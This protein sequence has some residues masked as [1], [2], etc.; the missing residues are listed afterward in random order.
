MC[1]SYLIAIYV[2]ILIGVINEFLKCK[3]K[4]FHQLR[5]KFHWFCVSHCIIAYIC[6]VISFF[7]FFLNTKH[8]H[9]AYKM[10]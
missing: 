6:I 8:E 9:V 2:S 7:F 4:H 10:C 3:T 1:L 5:R